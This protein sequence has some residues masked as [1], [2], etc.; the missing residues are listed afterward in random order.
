M[1]KHWIYAL[2]LVAAVTV[3]A[4][5]GAEAQGRFNGLDRNRDGVVT[6]AEWRGNDTSFRNQDRNGDGVLS[7]A[8]LNQGSTALVP[9]WWGYDA[10]RDGR[11]SRGEWP[12]ILVDF[13]LL[14][15]NDDGWLS[16]SEVNNARV[17]HERRHG[18]TVGT[19]G[20]KAV[21]PVKVKPNTPA[22]VKPNTPVKAK[23]AKPGKPAGGRGRGNGRG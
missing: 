11:V 6:R 5:A 4:P 16:R 12:G 9:V 18:N 14:D 1:S 22:K 17:V 8:E 21:K 20:K 13:D 23:P 19:A 2:G 7:G 10:N 3:A 15:T